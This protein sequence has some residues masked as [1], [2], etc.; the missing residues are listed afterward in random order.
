MSSE[1]V[2]VAYSDQLPA[3]AP[4]NAL[5]PR[6][7]Y[8]KALHEEYE[9]LQARP[10]SD[11]TKR[12]TKDVTAQLKE[13]GETPKSA[14]KLAE[15]TSTERGAVETTDAGPRGNTGARTKAGS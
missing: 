9:T 10:E 8:V 11:V 2:K 15:E 5:T 13:Y 3:G 1:K 7:A 12:R 6:Q 14:A 4:E